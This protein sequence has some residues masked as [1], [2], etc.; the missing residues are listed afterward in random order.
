MMRRMRFLSGSLALGDTLRANF[1]KLFT[2]ANAG[3]DAVVRSASSVGAGSRKERALIPTSL[4]ERVR[5][6][7]GV[8]DAQP[9]IQGYGQLTGADGKNIGGNGPPRLAAAQPGDEIGVENF[10]MTT[11]NSVSEFS[12]TRAAGSLK[13]ASPNC[14]RQSIR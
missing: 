3:T 10:P 13:P 7:D 14:R 11:P 6:V 5:T 12:A 1:D 4:I 8:L 2:N 9:Y